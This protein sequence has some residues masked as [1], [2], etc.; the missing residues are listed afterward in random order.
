MCLI[1]SQSTFSIRYRRNARP[2]PV[3]LMEQDDGRRNMNDLISYLYQKDELNKDY[4]LLMDNCKD[5][6][7]RIFDEIAKTKYL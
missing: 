5:F 1:T 4:L 3:K 6:A 7:K 2:E